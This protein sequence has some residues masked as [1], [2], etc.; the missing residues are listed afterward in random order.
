MQC[1]HYCYYIC[2]IYYMHFLH[3]ICH[4]VNTFVC[5]RI[6]K[7]MEIFRLSKNKTKMQQLKKKDR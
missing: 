7:G 6:Y 4:P 5:E 2:I 3:I 1:M